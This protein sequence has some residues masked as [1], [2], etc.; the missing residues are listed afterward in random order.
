MLHIIHLPHLKQR[1]YAVQVQG[2]MILRV[3]Y[4]LYPQMPGYSATTLLQVRSDVFSVSSQMFLML[5]D[6]AFHILKDR[7]TRNRDVI[8]KY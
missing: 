5:L 4:T 1:L 6:S 8:D 7:H 2:K 3:N